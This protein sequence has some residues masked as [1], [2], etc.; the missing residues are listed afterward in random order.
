MELGPMA[1]LVYLLGDPGSREAAVVDPAWDVERILEIAERDGFR[2]TD[3]LLTHAHPDHV[4]GVA[5]LSRRTG[6]RVHLH[7]SEAAWLRA[8]DLPLV[9]SEE[10]RPVKIGTIPVSVLHTPGHSPGSRCFQIGDRLI[11]GDTL[12][13]GACGRTDLPGGSPE[14]LFRS[15]GRLKALDDS[16]SLCPGHRYGER[17]KSTLGEEKRENVFLRASSLGEF[18]RFFQAP[19]Y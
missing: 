9:L 16:L 5:E 6:A 2:I 18:L 15:L 8:G 12:F 4:N 17:E 11:S 7:P 19:V 3:L 10:E 14:Q 1:N 13:I